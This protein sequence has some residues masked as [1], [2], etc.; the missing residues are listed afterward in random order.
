MMREENEVRA[1]LLAAGLGNRLHPL[2]KKWPKCLMPIG[3][4]PLL[5]HWLET[6]YSINVRE[7]LVNLHHHSEI[8]KEFLNRPRFK[9]WV[10]PVYEETLLGTAGTLRAN[11]DFFIIVQHF[12]YMQITG[13]NAILLTF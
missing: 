5:E 8:V 3:E 12:L 4:R 10:R 9:G 6:L 11:K 2:T 1:L 7:V 13:V